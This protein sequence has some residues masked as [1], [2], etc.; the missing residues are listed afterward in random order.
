MATYP[1]DLTTA[2][3][4]LRPST[5]AICVE[6]TVRGITHSKDIRYATDVVDSIGAAHLYLSNLEGSISFARATAPYATRIT[7]AGS[8]C[9]LRY[10]PSGVPTVYAT[11][12]VTVTRYRDI[13]DSTPW[14]IRSNTQETMRL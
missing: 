10:A 12:G 7:V 5:T 4:Y 8:T 1:T 13:L 14:R 9:T 3:S 6:A 2:I 11:Y